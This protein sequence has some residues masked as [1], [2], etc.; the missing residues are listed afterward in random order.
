[1]AI[2][3]I[4]HISGEEPIAGEVEEI[5]NPNDTM[6]KVSHPRKIDGKDLSYLAS[7]VTTVLWPLWRI[8][9]IEI[10]PSREEEELIGFVRE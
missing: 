5:P 10:I 3:I 7:N 8:N 9:F 2:G 6:V 4:L 1:M